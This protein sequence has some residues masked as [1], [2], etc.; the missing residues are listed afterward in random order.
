MLV[1]QSPDGAGGKGGSEGCLLPLRSRPDRHSGQRHR[2]AQAGARTA[3]GQACPCVHR[4]RAGMAT[5]ECR[6]TWGRRRVCPHTRVRQELPSTQIPGP[7][8]MTLQRPG[9]RGGAAPSPLFSVTS[10]DRPVVGLGEG[11]LQAG[12][13]RYSGLTLGNG[14]CCWCPSELLSCLSRFEE[15]GPTAVQRHREVRQLFQGHTGAGLE[16]QSPGPRVPPSSL[17]TLP[18]QQARQ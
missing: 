15:R 7:H 16:A 8:P 2:E 10:R 1:R 5:L 13:R 12:V 11:Q 18:V 9:G 14:P 17:H 6:P 4:H 3:A